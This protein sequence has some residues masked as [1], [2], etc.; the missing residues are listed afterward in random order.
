MKNVFGAS[1]S[2]VTSSYFLEKLNCVNTFE[3]LNQQLLHDFGI[4][5]ASDTNKQTLWCSCINYI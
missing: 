4:K 2:D 3:Q 1:M 5:Y